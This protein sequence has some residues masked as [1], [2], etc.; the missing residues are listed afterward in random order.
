MHASSPFLLSAGLML[1]ASFASN[2]DPLA[3]E[4]EAQLFQRCTACHLKTAQGVPGMFPPIN[5]RLGALAGTE[6]GRDYLVMVLN[7]GLMGP[8]TV[9]GRLYTNAMPAQGAALGDAGIASILNYLLTTFNTDTL[10]ADWKRFD[11]EEVQAIKLRYADANNQTLQQLRQR[12]VR[13]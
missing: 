2:A 3:P 5:Q 9:D 8:I 1:L 6:H 13:D 10:P 7:N 12:A 4:K 11:A